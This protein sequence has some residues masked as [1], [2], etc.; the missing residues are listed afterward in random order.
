[1]S[2]PSERQHYGITLDVDYVFHH[3]EELFLEMQAG[4]HRLALSTLRAADS[5]D[6]EL[7]LRV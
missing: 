6:A 4:N 1:M 2:S 7:G 3:K 5:I